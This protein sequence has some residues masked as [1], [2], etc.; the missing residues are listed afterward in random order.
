M[1]FDGTALWS[2]LPFGMS[3]I[4]APVTEPVLVGAA[5]SSSNAAAR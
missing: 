4:T 3:Q 5:D 1:S 2:V